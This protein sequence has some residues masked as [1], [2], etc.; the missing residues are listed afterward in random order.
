MTERQDK[1][2][3]GGTVIDPMPGHVA[4]LDGAM[5]EAY[6]REVGREEEGRRGKKRQEAARRGK[7][8]QNK[9]KGEN[10]DVALTLTID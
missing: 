10:S 8:R 3:V 5:C 1:T 7:K 6:V 4:G 2:R 9:A